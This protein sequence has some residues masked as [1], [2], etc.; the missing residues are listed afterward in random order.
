MAYLDQLKHTVEV[1]RRS[2]GAQN[3]YGEAIDTWAKITDITCLVQPKGGNVAREESGI[4][5]TST[6]KLFCLIGTNIRVGDKIKYSSKFFDVLNVKDAA[7]Q[8]HHLESDLR[9]NE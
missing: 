5:I 3:D 1:W 9:E 7:G 8:N 6:H 4:L 2:A